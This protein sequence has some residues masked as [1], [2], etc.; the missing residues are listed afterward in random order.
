MRMKTLRPDVSD[1]QAARIWAELREL[2]ARYPSKEHIREVLGLGRGSGR[3]RSLI[4]LWRGPVSLSALAEAIGVDA[5]Y[6]TIIVD[7]LEERGLV[8]RR[9]DPEDRRRKLVALTPAGEERTARALRIEWEPPPGFESLSP[10][11]LDTLEDLVRR[12]SVGTG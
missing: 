9:P 1:D 6:A 4:R 11:E 5:P 10:E 8:E 2:T 7:S 3:F 12:I